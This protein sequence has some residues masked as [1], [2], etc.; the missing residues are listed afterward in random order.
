MSLLRGALGEEKEIEVIDDVQLKKVTKSRLAIIKQI[1]SSAVMNNVAGKRP[2]ELKNLKE[3]QAYAKL[4]GY[5]PG[6]AYHYA[7]QRGFIKK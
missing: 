2:N 6:W 1:Q 4:K 5:K 3:I 7:K